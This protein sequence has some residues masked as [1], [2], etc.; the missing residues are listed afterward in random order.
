MNHKVSIF[1]KLIGLLKFSEAFYVLLDFIKS[2]LYINYPPSYLKK[3]D[4]EVNKKKLV[5]TVTKQ[6]CHIEPGA[7][8]S[9]LA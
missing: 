2:G 3:T 5:V 1:L 8:P 4:S 9:R 7:V 6:K